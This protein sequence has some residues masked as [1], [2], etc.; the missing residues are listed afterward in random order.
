MAELLRTCTKCGAMKPLEEYARRGE[1]RSPQC[2]EC[3]RTYAREYRRKNGDMLRA[4][5]RARSDRN[6]TPEAKVRMKGYTKAWRRRNPEYR[7]P[8][9]GKQYGM[10]TPE[11]RRAQ[12][13]VRRA[14]LS[15]KIQR[16][17]TC[18][19]CGGSDSRIEASHADYSKPLE[20][21]WL[22]ASCHREEDARGHGKGGW[23]H[24]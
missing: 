8:S 20:I 16:P 18:S 17:E 2:K 7:S 19:R 5:D 14:L 13:A 10:V 1:D 11:A 22:C 21:R 24:S 15:G 3:G 12:Q 6:K 9:Y 4:K 23:K